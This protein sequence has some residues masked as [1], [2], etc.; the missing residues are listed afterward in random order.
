[1]WR[2]SKHTSRVHDR[3]RGQCTPEEGKLS[4]AKEN[5][6]F[7]PQSV[8]NKNLHDPEYFGGKAPKIVGSLM[9]FG[10]ALAARARF[11]E[12]IKC[13]GVLIGV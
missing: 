12:L 4:H 3:D 5:L 8:Q 1:M 9:Y 2:R 6:D 10:I 7:N 13:I 11:D